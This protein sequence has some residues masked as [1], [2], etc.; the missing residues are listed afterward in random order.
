MRRAIL[1]LLMAA[2]PAK[3]DVIRPDGSVIVCYCTDS[4]G[5]RVE[6]GEMACLTI[7]KR[8]ITARC[9]MSLNVPIWR[10]VSEGCTPPLLSSRLRQLLK[11][12][13]DAGAVHPH[14]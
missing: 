5:D 11:P 6:M 1:L 3:A 8:R 13:F 9:D 14:I 7:G 12:A 4:T 2:A 10:E